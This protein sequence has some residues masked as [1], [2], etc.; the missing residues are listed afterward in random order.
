M[1]VANGVLADTRVMKSAASVAASGREVIVVGA[2]ASGRVE[3]LRVGDV[4]VIL[5]PLVQP[6]SFERRGE[7]VPETLD[8]RLSRLLRPLG[9]WSQSSREAAASRRSTRQRRLATAVQRA[10]GRSGHACRAARGSCCC[11]ARGCAV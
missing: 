11:R 2:S 3:E 8:D 7:P 9:F 10:A 4:R 5:Q 6:A 1:V